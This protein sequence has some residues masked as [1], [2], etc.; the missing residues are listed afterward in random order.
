MLP[1]FKTGAFRER[2]LQKEGFP[3]TKTTKP[4]A[5]KAS[6]KLERD[7]REDSYF[8]LD[9]ENAVNRVHQIPLDLETTAP[10]VQARIQGVVRNLIVDSGSC[11]SILQP[12]VADDPI[13]CT[14]RSPYGV[15]GDTLRVNG[16]QTISFEIDEVPYRHTFL[17]CSLPTNA[18]GILGTDFLK[19][20]HA[21][22]N[23][24]KFTLTLE[25]GKGSQTVA[26]TQQNRGERAKSREEG[27]GLI[28]QT[29]MSEESNSG[30][31]TD[32]TRPEEN[33]TDRLDNFSQRK[34]QSVLK[35]RVETLGDVTSATWE[36][37]SRESVT[38]GARSKQVVRGRLSKQRNQALP[39]LV[40]V[41]PA[42]LPIEGMCTARVVTWVS[43][44]TGPDQIRDL[45]VPVD[46]PKTASH[47]PTNPPDDEEN[48]VQKSSHTSGTVLLVIANFSDEPLVLQKACLL[49]LAQEISETSIVSWC[50]EKS[51]EAG[52]ERSFPVGDRGEARSPKFLKYIDDK[53]AHLASEDRQIIEPVLIRYRH[54]FHDEEENDFKSTQVVEHR[55]ETGNAALIRKA[56]YRVPFALKGE[57]QNQVQEMLKKGVI[58]ESQS[59]WSSPVILVPKRSLDGK[60]KYRFCVDFRALNAVTKFDSYPLPRFED[61]TSRDLEGRGESFSRESEG[62]KGVPN[63]KNGETSPIIF[64]LGIVLPQVS[65]KVCRN[66]KTA[67]RTY[68]K[69][70]KVRVECRVS[71]IL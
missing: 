69:R 14:N 3:E 46:R 30:V 43:R 29:F 61:T 49:G 40:C 64:G 12:G 42:T 41:E 21:I 18:A 9:P 71:T 15:T 20:K 59:P 25:G 70:R 37:T 68:P 38:I 65:T 48:P 58:R 2:L 6:G 55:I 4:G 19:S 27:S 56:Q 36:V 16:E 35:E 33:Q 51:G 62:C 52:L 1:L 53:L 24:E 7:G 60:P 5:G 45:D 26:T 54:V 32:K 44:D 11:C 23:L 57:M 31:G 10:S 47:K 66:C 8:R 63:S 17:V 28:T 22:L 13:G 67:V 34:G 50:E 39:N